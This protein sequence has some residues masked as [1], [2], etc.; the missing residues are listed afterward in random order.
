[1]DIMRSP[2]QNCATDSVSRLS[3][4]GSASA[5]DGNERSTQTLPIRANKFPALL[6]GLL[7]AATG[8]GLYFLGVIIGFFHFF[9]DP[10]NQWRRLVELIVWYSGIPIVAG[11]ILI[12]GDLFLLLPKKRAR[13]SV[14][15]NPPSNCDLTVVLTAYNDE[16]SIGASVE[17][18]RSH[19]NVK[20]VIVVD[21]NSKDRTT[22]VARQAGALVVHETR[23]GY[24]YCVWRA[25]HEGTQYSDTELTLLC[26]GDM[27]FR[28][29]DIEKFLAYLPHVDIVNGTRIVEQLRAYRTQ[30]TTS[31]YYGNFFAGKLLEAKHVGKG[32]FT[33]VGTTYK[34]CRN[35]ALKRLL[36]L[37][38]P[39]INLE[40]N[41]HF[42][43][44]ALEYGFT[45]VECPVTFHN[46]VGIS[47]GGNVSNG[48][49]AKVG[50]KMIYGI[51][52]GWKKPGSRR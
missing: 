5:K 12:L 30:L 8:I 45:I 31:M 47:K 1:M 35:S 27:T 18:F 29:Y 20:R 33:D 10:H 9:L 40:F 6:F 2:K 36:P 17:D 24:G 41:A 4:I 28:S 14:A 32:T 15:W 3:L 46:R 52:L 23:Q 48:R 42:L 49:A 19:P 37:V 25:L 50:L 11:L 13:D 51:V 38:N 26:E 16:A 39:E 7:I 44:T 22:E 34:L 43:D 21:N